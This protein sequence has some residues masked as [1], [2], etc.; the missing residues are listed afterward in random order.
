MM[1]RVGGWK[2]RVKTDGRKETVLIQAQR[3]VLALQV[4][5]DMTRVR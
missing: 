5:G 2:K 3:R 4:I 1:L